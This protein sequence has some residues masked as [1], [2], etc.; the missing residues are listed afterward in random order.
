MLSEPNLEEARAFFEEDVAIC[1]QIQD[2]G[3][4][5]AAL[6]GLGATVMRNDIA[7]ARP[8]IEESVALFREVGN[9]AWLIGAL[10]QLGLVAWLEGDYVQAGRLFEEGLGL[11]RELQEQN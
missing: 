2:T 7:T 4:L 6:W 8:I 3:Y 11:C 5:A 10:N 9:K 1:W